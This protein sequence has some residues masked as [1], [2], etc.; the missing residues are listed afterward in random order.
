MEATDRPYEERLPIRVGHLVTHP[1]QYF[2]PLYRMLAL[3]G[4]IDLTVY[5]FST[6][7]LET[8]F[9]TE[10]NTSLKWDIPLLEGYRSVLAEDGSKH[11]VVAGFDFK[12]SWSILN[13]LW[14]ER[15]DVIW[16][17]GYASLNACAAV[18][19]GHLRGSKVMLREEQTLLTPRTILKRLVKRL[20]LPLIYKHVAGLYIGKHSRR[21]FE[22]YGTS[23][24]RLFP[25]HYC[26]DNSFLS[27]CR[28]DLL[29]RRIELRN[30][31]GITA[32]HPVILFSGK[33]IDKKQPMLLL[34]AFA[35]VR[36]R[37][38]CSLLFAGD[39]PLRSR[40][41]QE[42]FAE[43]I[44][45]VH[46]AGFLNQTEMPM[47]YVASDI[48]VLPSAYQE[49][50][51]LVVNEAMNFS[52]PVIV[53]DQVGCSADLVRDGENGY[54]FSS[55][56][57]TALENC[58]LSLVGSSERRETY[59]R[60]SSEIIADYSM[61][62]CASQIADACASLMDNSRR[63]SRFDESPPLEHDSSSRLFAT[64]DLT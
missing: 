58:L 49:T 20:T 8:Y 27:R 63:T 41:E 17:H 42:T 9:D 55:G 19:I 32:E 40:L 26:V 14:T 52:L 7:G 62:V 3:K 12:L 21:F 23:S 50:W 45:D 60:R 18:V 25:T 61:E 36:K 59:G 16:L 1:I 33:L 5:F 15:Y 34:K 56:D 28:L 53:S 6:Q 35:N 31:F 44:P 29:P 22:H 30:H 54:I 39:G 46:F 47:A 64:T 24:A 57:V 13:S 10:F 43:R 4:V 51:G 48:F 38:P 2:A 11:K 37:F